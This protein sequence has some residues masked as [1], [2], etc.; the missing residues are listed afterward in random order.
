MLVLPPARLRRRRCSAA[1]RASFAAD[2]G[3]SELAEE[4]DDAKIMYGYLRVIDEN[5]SLPKFVFISWVRPR[6]STPA[7]WPTPSACL[8]TMPL[9]LSPV[10]P[11]RGPV[12]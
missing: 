6:R 9:L 11:R 3:I 10:V 1:C 4:A 7:A 2:G 5:T 12:R 8:L